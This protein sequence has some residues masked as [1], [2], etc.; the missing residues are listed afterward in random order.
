LKRYRRR[1]II[2]AII[3]MLR[4]ITNLVHTITSDNGKEF[5]FHEEV[6]KE[7]NIKFYFCNPYASWQRGLN[8]HTNGLIREFIPKKSE[9]DNISRT[10][11]VH[12]QNRLNNRP[13]KILEYLVLALSLRKLQMRYFLRF[14]KGN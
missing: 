14:Y 8:E 6:A 2:K 11:I 7:L 12:I 9:F 1:N 10:E 4:P 13:R 3:E 5:S